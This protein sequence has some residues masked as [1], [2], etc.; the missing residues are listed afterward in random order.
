[1]RNVYGTIHLNDTASA[2]AINSSVG[3]P[4]VLWAN[5]KARSGNGAS[6]YIGSSSA[7]NSTNGFELAAGDA[8]SE[9]YRGS[10]AEPGSISG[11]RF[12][13]NSTSTGTNL[14]FAMGLES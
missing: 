5:L 13:V 1:M 11:S 7:V 8:L 3:E 10:N 9:D 12:W 2:V 14:D 4:R 6:M